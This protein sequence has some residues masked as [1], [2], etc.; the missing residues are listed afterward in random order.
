M[1]TISSLAAAIVAEVEPPQR[2]AAFLKILDDLQRV[3]GRPEHAIHLGRDDDIARLADGEQSLA[4]GPQPERD[5]AGDT[6][7]VGFE[8][9]NIGNR[10]YSP[11]GGRPRRW[12]SL[13]LCGRGGLP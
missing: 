3:R 2:D 1:V 9:Q 8:P 7:I 6:G 5:T 10:G 4:L 13:R 12:V 11:G